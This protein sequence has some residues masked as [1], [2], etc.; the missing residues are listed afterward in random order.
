MHGRPST[1]RRTS[2]SSRCITAVTVPRRRLSIV[3][4]D[5]E[6]DELERD[7]DHALQVGDRNMLV[8]RVHLLHPVRE[9]DARE[10]PGV[11]HV[12]VGAA[13]AV[14]GLRSDAGTFD[15]LARSPKHR[16]VEVE[17]VSGIALA[18]A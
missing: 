16:L 13:A 17:S 18:N 4:M 1:S 15:P 2:P 14:D 6:L 10:A 5:A 9:V 3:R 12:R 7:T 11:E 8:R